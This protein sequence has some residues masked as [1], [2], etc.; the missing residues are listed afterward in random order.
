[1]SRLPVDALL[2]IIDG[3]GFTGRSAAIE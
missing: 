1:L 3:R 2:V